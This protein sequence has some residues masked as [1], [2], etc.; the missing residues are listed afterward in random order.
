MS[1]IIYLT[2][3]KLLSHGCKIH[4]TYKEFIFIE[5]KQEVALQCH[6]IA[7]HPVNS[8]HLTRKGERECQTLVQTLY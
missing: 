8:C 2:C 1:F 7:P 4:S 6:L 3:A 5:E